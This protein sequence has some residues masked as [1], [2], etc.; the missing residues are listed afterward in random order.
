MSQYTNNYNAI[1]TRENIKVI[2]SDSYGGVRIEILEYQKFLG[3]SDFKMAQSLYFM[4]QQKMKVRQIVAYID[5][6]G[7]KIEPGAMSYFQGPLEMVS[8]VTGTN[9]IG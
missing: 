7:V 1:G 3:M 4:E 8:G 2:N 5:N 9:F 6:D